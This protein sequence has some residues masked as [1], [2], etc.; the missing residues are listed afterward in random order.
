MV[1]SIGALVA[2]TF[3]LAADAVAKGAAGE[4]V[5]DGY[6]ALKSG[7]SPFAQKEIAELEPRPRSVGMQ[8][9]I[10]EIVDAQSEETKT[11]LRLLAET[12]VAGLKAGAP[13]GLDV[14]RLTALEA[15]FG[16][17]APK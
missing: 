6:N 4:A 3:G 11:A 14:D 16:A 12:L 17:H 10:A 13:T 7:L 2:G 5:L 1:D 15:Q 9:V 8:I